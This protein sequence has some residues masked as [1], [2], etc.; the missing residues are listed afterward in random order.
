MKYLKLFNEANGMFGSQD[1]YWSLYSETKHNVT[2][3]L[4]D[5][6]DAGMRCKPDAAGLYRIDLRID[7]IDYQKGIKFDDVRESISWFLEVNKSAISKYNYNAKIDIRLSI[8]GKLDL[9]FDSS[10]LDSK[11]V[12]DTIAFIEIIINLTKI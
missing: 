8:K 12:T 5:L 4:V 10:K 7:P 2:L 9:K 3:C 11:K 6:M 1:D